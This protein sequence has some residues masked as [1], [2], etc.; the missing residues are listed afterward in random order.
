MNLKR[1]KTNNERTLYDRPKAVSNKINRY[2][3]N[4]EGRLEQLK[5]NQNNLERQSEHSG[6]R[7]DTSS[8]V[9]FLILFNPSIMFE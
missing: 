4:T 1:S 7:P 9:V 2:L 6:L 8:L 5:L 3:I